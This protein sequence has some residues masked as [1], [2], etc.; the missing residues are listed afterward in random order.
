[1]AMGIVHRDLKPA[2]LFLTT[3]GDGSARVKVLDFG[4]SKIARP[5]PG[6]TGVHNGGLTT[7]ATIMGTPCFMSPEQLRSTRDVDGRADV[8]SLGAILY[9]LLCGAPPYE[10]ESNADVSA[11]IIRDD[12]P[13]LASVR[14]DV[15]AAMEAIVRR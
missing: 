14:P 3:A 7:T 15:P 2:N 12:P 6:D 9:A 8:W 13:P 10:G 5:E 4:I 11:K 1:D